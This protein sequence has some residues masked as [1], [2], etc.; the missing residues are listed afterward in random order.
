M[1]FTGNAWNSTGAFV[2][3]FDFTRSDGRDANIDFVSNAGIDDKT[4]KCKINVINNAVTTAL[5]TAGTWYK[6]NWTNTSSYTVKWNINNNRVTYQP[7]HPAYI[8]IIVSGNI[9]ANNNNRT[10][11]IGIVKN[12]VTGT[13]YG[14][15][16][17]RLTAA[18]QPFQYSTTIY[19][20]NVARN[21]YFELYVSSNNNGDIVVFQDINIFVNAQ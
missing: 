17:L 18:N 2:S 12:G 16:T 7:R 13:R 14:E 20:Q 21:D 19:I 3:G 1:F 8:F 6:A 9:S 11:N 5:P 4:P 10:I 15:T